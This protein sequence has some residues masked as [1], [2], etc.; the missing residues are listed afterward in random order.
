[1][2]ILNPIYIKILL[3][4]RVKYFLNLLPFFKHKNYTPF[5]IIGH[6]RTGTSLLH[7]YLNSHS[8]ILSLNEALG[9][10]SDGKPAFRAYSKSIKVVGFKYFYEYIKNEEKRK[11]L[12][13]LLSD[14]KIKVIKIHRRNYLRTYLS[15]RIAEK[16]N[17][18]SSTE[19]GGLSLKNKQISL[20]KEECINAFNNYA[21]IE[22]DT[23]IIL[24]QYNIPVF[25]V[26]YDELDKHPTEVM[27]KVQNFLE[28]KKQATF[29]LLT[30][31]N[32]EKISELIL[33]YQ[34]L[35]S[36][37]KGTEYE[38]YFEA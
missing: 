4:A 37:F 33:N 38:S 9:Y 16:T 26:D 29:S 2:N 1:M 6:P 34:E 30:K 15:L 10:S 28:V 21:T 14:F 7:T 35:K 36:A 3:K 27:E 20:S 19:S 22:N 32:P 25:E 12:I 23:D 31:Q 17:E 13:Y 8:N 24:R 18:W 11:I 5:L